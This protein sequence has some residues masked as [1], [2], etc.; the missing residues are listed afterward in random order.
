M[1][2]SVFWTNPITT[3]LEN[4]I[5][6][7]LVNTV[8]AQENL[9]HGDDIENEKVKKKTGKACVWTWEMTWCFVTE[10][11]KK[12]VTAWRTQVFFT[13]R[14]DWAPH[15][16]PFSE[17][18]QGSRR[19]AQSLSYYTFPRLSPE[20]YIKAP[21]KRVSVVATWTKVPYIKLTYFPHRK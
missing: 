12:R 16:L 17:S 11:E 18:V 14:G 7:R 20:I 2:V 1:D 15:C 19:P 6:S 10:R 8:R 5:A 21:S 13:L 4:R 3:P 9:W